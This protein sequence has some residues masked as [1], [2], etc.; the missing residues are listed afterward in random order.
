MQEP[1]PVWR[2]VRSHLTA[3]A[4]LVDD[5]GDGPVDLM[6]FAQHFQALASA[7]LAALTSQ[8]KTSMRVEAT[9]K[10]LNLGTPKSA[11]L[12]FLGRDQSPSSPSSN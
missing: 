9:V 2:N 8:G 7:Y 12:R 3:M 4:Q 5:A 11:L 10:A 6:H 1:T